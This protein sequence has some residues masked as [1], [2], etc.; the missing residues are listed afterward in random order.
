[1]K[2]R[3][4]RN[5]KKDDEKRIGLK[6]MRDGLQEFNEIVIYCEGGKDYWIGK[7]WEGD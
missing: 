4:D 1:M 2:Q 7:A 6:G 5:E 3:F